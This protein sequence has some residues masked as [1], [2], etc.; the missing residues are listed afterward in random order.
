M[1][2]IANPSLWADNGGLIGLVIFALFF[3]LWA[4]AKVLSN[5]LNNHRSDLSK[6]ME[7][8]AKEREEWGLIVDSRQRENNQLQRETN[9]AINAM[10]TALNGMSLA[11]NNIVTTHNKKLFDYTHE[12]DR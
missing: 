8:H 7:L 9:A 5:I 11:L 1:P 12:A 10:A 6:V 2:P 4:Y 3:V